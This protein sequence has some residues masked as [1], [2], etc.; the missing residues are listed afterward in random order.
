MSFWSTLGE[1][2]KVALAILDQLSGDPV[3][4]TLQAAMHKYINADG[5]TVMKR[6]TFEAKLEKQGTFGTKTV[7]LTVQEDGSVYILESGIFGGETIFPKAAGVPTPHEFLQMLQ[8]REAQNQAAQALDE[9]EKR[10]AI[11]RTIF[12]MFGK[13]AKTDLHV[14]EDEVNAI[15]AIMVEEEFDQDTQKMAIEFLNEAKTTEVPFKEI[16]AEFAQYVEDIEHRKGILYR[17]VK[18]AAADGTLH[19]AEEQSLND[20][21]TAFGLSSDFVTQALE[22]MLPDIEKYYAVLGCDPLV[23][24]DELKRHYRELSLQYH[25]DRISS[26]DLAPDF[27]KFAKEKFQEI[28]NAYEIITEHRK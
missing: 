3:Y 28:Q 4:P 26:K 7:T 10:N 9:E 13:I 17:L 16:A 22:E 19:A 20:A 5:Y 11:F 1:I 6:E 14:S 15:K 8:E 12:L 25:P 27:H 23:S 21:A 18:I 24:D 2:G